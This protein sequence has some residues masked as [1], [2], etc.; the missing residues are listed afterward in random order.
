MMICP[1]CGYA[2][3]AGDH[4]CSVCGISLEI[5]PEPKPRRKRA[6][7]PPVL[8]MVLMVAIGFAVYF[9]FPAQPA[10]STAEN[11]YPWFEIFDGTLYFHEDL[12]TG[13]RELIV[14]DTV[15]G[16][17]VTSLSLDCFADCDTLDT[18]TLPETLEKIQDGAF[19]DCDALRGIMIPE[20][21]FFIGN[22]SFENCP[23]LEAV[24][25]SGVPSYVG[26]D[27]FVDCQNLR[28]IYFNGYNEQ[29]VNLYNEFL[30]PYTYVACQDGIFPQGA[31]P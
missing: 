17:T 25:I 31:N 11:E 6:I 27:A 29:W 19:R 22:N 26:Q 30:T 18:V 7:W 13:D 9:L 10:P 23:A 21:V 1:N 28:Y 5:Q 12:Y 20:S 3:E 14:P 8:I 15:D 2:Y 24:C 4:Y 16:Q